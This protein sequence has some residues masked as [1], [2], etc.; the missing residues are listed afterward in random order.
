MRSRTTTP[1]LPGT[2]GWLPAGLAVA[3]IVVAISPPARRR[4]PSLAAQLRRGLRHP[5]GRSRGVAHR[6]RG[7]HPSPDASDPVLAQR[8]RST[9]GPLRKRPDI[10]PVHVMVGDLTVSLHGV[11]DRREDAHEI[12]RTV[13]DLPC[14]DQ[15]TSHLPTGLGGGDTGPSS[16]RRPVGVR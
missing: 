13:L 8:I 4:I 3:G 5:A 9:R 15:V 16:V 2:R 10:P 11:V 7:R 1:R 14:V 6:R 12:E